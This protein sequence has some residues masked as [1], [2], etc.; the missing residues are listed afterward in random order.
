VILN[1]EATMSGL[2][3]TEDAA[4][5]LENL[6]LTRDV[7]AQRA[8]TIRRLAL[9]HGERVLDIGCGPGFLCESIAAAVA[10]DGAVVGI[11]ISSD[12][13]EL[14]KRRNPPQWLSFVVGDASQLAA[15]DASFDVV[16]C[17]QVAEYVPDVGRVLSEAFRVLR[18][19]G[20]AV[21]VATDW[22]ALIWHSES[23]D[24][25]TS[26]LKSWEAHCAHPHLPRSLAQRLVGAGFRF[27]EL[28]VIPILNLR[29]DDELYSKGLAGLI[30]EF[31]GRKNEIPAES[32]RAW[33]DEFG[34]LSEAGQYFFSSNRYIFLA[35]KAGR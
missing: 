23:Q 30:R 7:A 4:R 29:W 31:V 2:E 16:V 35:S 26:V 10:G 5:R 14:C 9:S 25:M 12:L 28:G 8:E 32:L 11:D 27:D 34:L 3:F 6:Y 17:T 20:R 33:Y 15:P 21:F 18:R 13:I 22:D 19:G 24:R 1:F